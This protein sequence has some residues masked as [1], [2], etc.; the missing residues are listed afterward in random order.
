MGNSG[1]DGWGNA[2]P[3]RP[4]A[5]INNSNNIPP[6]MRNMPMEGM[7]IFPPR[8][9]FEL[10]NKFQNIPPPFGNFPQFSQPQQNSSFSFFLIPLIYLI[11]FFVEN[12][13]T[14]LHTQTRSK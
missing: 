9:Q 1:L 11:Y 12:S 10:Q 6:G 3:Y 14:Y 13:S 5:A 8:N 7:P 2:P 4:F